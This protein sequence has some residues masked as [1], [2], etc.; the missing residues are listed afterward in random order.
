MVSFDSLDS[1]IFD[2]LEF[3]SLI[4]KL[5]IKEERIRVVS[6]SRLLLMESLIIVSKNKVHPMESVIP[7]SG[8]SY[9]WRGI[10]EKLQNITINNNYGERTPLCWYENNDDV[11]WS[12]YLLANYFRIKAEIRRS[13]GNNIWGGITSLYQNE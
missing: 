11:W 8:C 5:L 1:V 2:H 7:E 13:G 6:L 12:Y 3:L 10:I 4:R 9:P